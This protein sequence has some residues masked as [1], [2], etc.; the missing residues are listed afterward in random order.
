MVAPSSS[1]DK[2]GPWAT[3]VADVDDRSID[4][5]TP[6]QWMGHLPY[7]PTDGLQITEVKVGVVMPV[8]TPFRKAMM[9]AA[10]FA[11]E[12]ANA[13]EGSIVSSLGALSPSIRF[14][15]TPYDSQLETSDA[16]ATSTG[17]AAYRRALRRQPDAILGAAW[18]STSMNIARLAAGDNIVQM[19]PTSTSDEL[20]DVATYPTFS[21]IHPPDAYSANRMAHMAYHT[22]GYRRIAIIHVDDTLGT[23]YADSLYRAE[24]EL[25]GLRFVCRA[26]FVAGSASQVDEALATVESSHANVVIAIVHISDFTR[27]SGG[28]KNINTMYRTTR[29]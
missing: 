17:E 25:P 3:A 4:L 26:S 23:S 1:P 28:G 7:Q 16:H 5:H 6:I 20:S 11:F 10:L 8:D 27:A 24:G 2:L 29:P 13:A 21:R 12:D 22:L 9:C 15:F 18:S 19:S 14:S